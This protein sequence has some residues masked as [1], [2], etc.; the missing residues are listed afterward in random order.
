MAWQTADERESQSGVMG[1]VCTTVM[2]VRGNVVVLRAQRVAR[3]EAIDTLLGFVGPLSA[4]VGQ[5]I[6][7]PVEW[8]QGW[9]RSES[10]V[11]AIS[12]TTAIRQT[13]TCAGSLAL[14]ED[15]R[16][17]ASGR[18]EVIGASAISS[19]WGRDV[20]RVLRIS[21]STGES[22]WLRRQRQMSCASSSPISCTGAGE[23]DI[24]RDDERPYRF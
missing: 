1:L 20:G 4:G 22:R 21:R 12:P 7:K 15:T 11:G 8:G 3:T 16:Y 23:D 2:G 14:R 24:G 13:I 19:V 9:G 5:W 18:S 6:N 17:F 10:A